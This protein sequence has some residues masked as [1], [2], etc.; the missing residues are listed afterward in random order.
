MIS[1]EK[2]KKQLINAHWYNIDNNKLRTRAL[3]LSKCYS[4]ELLKKIIDDTYSFAKYLLNIDTV[5]KG[6][7]L[8]E[9]QNPCINYIGM[10]L[11]D[12]NFA[13]RLFYYENYV[14]SEKIL[15]NIFGKELVIEVKEA[16]S[17]PPDNKSYYLF[18]HEFNNN[19]KETKKKLLGESKVLK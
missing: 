14:I 19:L 11:I 2:Y 5:Y 13:D 18:I 12:E 8:M 16:M 9:I 3:C 17:N 4:D 1:I 6:Y 15:K 10:G 7:F